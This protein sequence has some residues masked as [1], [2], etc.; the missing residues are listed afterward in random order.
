MK[1]GC[2]PSYTH[3]MFQAAAT[4]THPPKPQLLPRALLLSLA[5]HGVVLTLGMAYLRLDGTPLA[6]VPALP[7]KLI[8][9]APATPSPVVEALTMPM[10]SAAPAVR[11]R[12][13][14]PPAR[15]TQPAPP[16]ANTPKAGSASPQNTEASPAVD[17]AALRQ[18][19]IA[20]GRAARSFRNY[21]VE[22]RAAGIRGRVALRLAV[23]AS[24]QML[25]LRVTSGSGHHELDQAALQ[26]FQ[27]AAAQAHVPES[28]L[29]QA[30]SIDLS[31]DFAPEDQP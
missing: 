12:P 13:P 4:V 28:L 23:S 3:G 9:T 19:H 10:P 27:R 5:V 8:G 14:A 11:P 2:S 15:Q 30:F 21:P 24:G 26:M 20:L 22:L 7:A 31:I 18:Y 1:I 25:G 17:A 6:S 16:L 29:G